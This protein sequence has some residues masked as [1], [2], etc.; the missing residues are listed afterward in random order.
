M[1]PRY[2]KLHKTWQ[3]PWVSTC[4]ITGIGLVLLAGAAFFQTVNQIIFVSVKA[5]GFQVA[6]YYGLACFACAWKFRSTPIKNYK[7]FIILFFWPLISAAFMAFIFI[8]CAYSFDWMTTALG[9]GAIVV[10]II[11]FYLNRKNNKHFLN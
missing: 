11:P 2:A 4:V 1:H 10:G 3:T 9:I 7:K 6:F 8:Y 5:I